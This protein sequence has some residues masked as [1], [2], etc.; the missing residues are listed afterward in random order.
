MFGQK[1]DRDRY[2]S[3]ACTWPD[4]LSETE[5]AEMNFYLTRCNSLAVDYLGETLVVSQFN[6][7]QLNTWGLVSVQILQD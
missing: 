6:I 4:C 1:W 7:F 5:D 2:N 3:G